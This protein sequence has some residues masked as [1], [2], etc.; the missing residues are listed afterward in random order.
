MLCPPR[1]SMRVNRCQS[2]LVWCT[3]TG[4]KQELCSTVDTARA[5]SQ[6]FSYS[7]QGTGWVQRKRGGHAGQPPLLA[8][9]KQ[10]AASKQV[11]RANK[12][13]VLSSATRGG[14]GSISSK[15]DLHM[16]IHVCISGMKGE[17]G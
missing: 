17:G 14:M 1:Q 2:P 11:Q 3:V 8:R 6:L 15:E 7:S 13:A 12:C 16:R 5:C 10:A 9:T 4:L